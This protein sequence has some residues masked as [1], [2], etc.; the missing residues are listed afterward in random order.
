MP[1]KEVGMMARMLAFLS[2]K[3]NGEA[4][5]QAHDVPHAYRECWYECQRIINGDKFLPRQDSTEQQLRDVIWVA[6]RMGCYDASDAM[7]KLIKEK[8]NDGK[9]KE[10]NTGG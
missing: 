5:Y 3:V 10:G 2:G 6:D 1:K 9:P 4:I 7:R 8:P